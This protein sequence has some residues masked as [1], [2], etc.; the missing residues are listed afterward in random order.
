M[1]SKNMLLLERG[2]FLRLS[3][4]FDFYNSS[5]VYVGLSSTGDFK[6]NGFRYRGVNFVMQRRF[7]S[8]LCKKR[9]FFDV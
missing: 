2:L 7:Y 9:I 1:V 6:V 4:A 8:M 5:A 3:T